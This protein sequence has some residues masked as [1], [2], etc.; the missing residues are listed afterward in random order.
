MSSHDPPIILAKIDA[1]DEANKQLSTKFDVNGFPTLKILR[2]GGKQVQGFKTPR[3]AGEIVAYLKKQLGPASK[4]IKSVE[5]AAKLIDEN[6]VIT[7][8]TSRRLIFMFL[9]S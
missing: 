2:D 7:V 5:D 8:S 1:S 9:T 6:G 3:Q 4:E